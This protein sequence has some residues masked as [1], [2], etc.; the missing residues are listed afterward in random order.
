MEKRFF[1][2]K[3]TRN[4]LGN[5]GRKFKSASV[6]L[7]TY[8]DSDFLQKRNGFG[9]ERHVARQEERMHRLTLGRVIYQRNGLGM[10]VL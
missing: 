9:P 8:L 10:V 7:R 6:W 4:H 2:P 5:S 3:H 1:R